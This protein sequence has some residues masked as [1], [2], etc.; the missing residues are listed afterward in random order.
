MANTITL[1]AGMRQ[2]LYSMQTT[3]M[4]MEKTRQYFC[5]LDND[6]GDYSIEIDPR[7]VEPGDI[8]FLRSLGFNRF[9]LGVQDV[10]EQVQEAV[11]RFQPIDETVS[12][13]EAC[14]SADAKSI[15]MDLIYGLPFQSLESFEQT[16]DIVIKP[17]KIS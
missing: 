8:Q 10:N 11:N 2:N 7:S 4:L 5:L 6:E 3:Q 1:T 12:I 17:R 13:I 15:N 16:L 14:R 9:S